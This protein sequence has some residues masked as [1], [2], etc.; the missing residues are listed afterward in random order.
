MGNFS[1][2]Y[3]KDVKTTQKQENVN[4]AL[5]TICCLLNVAPWQLGVFNSSKG[6]IAGNL[7][8]FLPDNEVIDYSAHKN[9]KYLRNHR[10]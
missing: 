5:R 4:D 10:R 2:M 7:K 1:E 8:V 6:L 3:Y 9:G